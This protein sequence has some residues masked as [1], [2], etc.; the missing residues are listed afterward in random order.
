[1]RIGRWPNIALWKA[2]RHDASGASV[3]VQR[4]AVTG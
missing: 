1:M 4:S 3:D 2:A